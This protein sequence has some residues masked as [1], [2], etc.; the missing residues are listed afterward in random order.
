MSQALLKPFTDA[1]TALE[2]FLKVA[3]KNGVSL[4]SHSFYSKKVRST[5]AALRKAFQSLKIKNPPDQHPG[6]AYQLTTI[7]PMIQRLVSMYPADPGD[8]LSLVREIQFKSESD[9]AA[10]LEEVETTKM[11]PASPGL[12]LPDDIFESRHGV[13][14]KILWEVNTCYA[15][16]CWNGAATMLRRILENLII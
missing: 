6:V 2:K 15:G 12:F 8:M 3:K 11:S 14:S 5:L 13:L 1:L 10:E 4:A 7:E 9:L 16:E